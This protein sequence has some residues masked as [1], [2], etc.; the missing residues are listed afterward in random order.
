MKRKDPNLTD[1]LCAMILMY[2]E[3][4]HEVAKTMTRDDILA[5]YE[6]DHDPVPVAIAID[7]G[8]TPDQ[9]NHPSNIRGK[10]PEVHGWKSAKKDVPEIAK[11]VRISDAHKEF[12]R[13]VL[14]KAGV[15]TGQE[16]G[17]TERH[18]F[19]WGKRPWPSK[20]FQKKQPV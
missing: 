1:K 10:F 12:Q 3:I 7:L 11:A 6:W 17:Q 5:L 8:W 9:Y 2:L 18:K 20:P 4:P 13:K 14:A 15:E 16:T 19:R